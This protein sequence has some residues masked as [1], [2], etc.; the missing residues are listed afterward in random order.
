MRISYHTRRDD[1]STVKVVGGSFTGKIDEKTVDRLVV[2]LFNVTIKNSG[3][4][5]FVDS[6]G[7]QVQLYL[8]VDPSE[9]DLGKAA[10]SA[11]SAQRAADAASAEEKALADA[12]EVAKAMEG[13]SHAQIIERLRG[14]V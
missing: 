9:T 13:L 10:L 5:V 6:Q 1:D 11:W 8:A 4:A 7:R 2:S 12:D 3:R 14:K